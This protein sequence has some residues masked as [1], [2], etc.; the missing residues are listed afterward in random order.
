[1]ICVEQ[2]RAKEASADEQ[3]EGGFLAVEAHER[4]D[5]NKQRQKSGDCLHQRVELGA[6]LPAGIP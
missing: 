3:I 6:A 2:T 4:H 1:M 5:A